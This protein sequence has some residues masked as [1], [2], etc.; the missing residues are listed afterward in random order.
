MTDGLD[1][2]QRLEHTPNATLSYRRWELLLHFPD[3]EFLRLQ[4]PHETERP[5]QKAET[6]HGPYIC[7]LS[8]G[9]LG[10][11]TAIVGEIG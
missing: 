10:T 1:H 3:R 2:L 11:L 4:R 7:T 5:S 9:A 8:L 6:E